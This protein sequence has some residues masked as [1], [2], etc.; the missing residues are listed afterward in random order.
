MLS[1]ILSNWIRQHRALPVNFGDV[2]INYD[3]AYFEEND[4]AVPQSLEELT[5][6]EYRGLLVVHQPGHFI[7]RTSIS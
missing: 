6:P 7:S 2:C 3:R 4:L 1:R 5:N